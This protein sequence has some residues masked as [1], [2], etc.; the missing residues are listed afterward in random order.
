MRN[1]QAKFGHRAGGRKVALGA[2]CSE[3]GVWSIAT[4]LARHDAAMIYLHQPHVHSKFATSIWYIFCSAITQR[5]D[6]RP[7]IAPTRATASSAVRH[8]TLHLFETELATA[9]PLASTGVPRRI[10][11]GEVVWYGISTCSK[12]YPP[13]AAS[14][15]LGGD[16]SP[17]F[18]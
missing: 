1:E 12:P 4:A 14:A 11:I 18:G 9:A 10:T 17:S 16:Q 2:F 15:S 5:Q 8:Q 3:A 6:N 7:S 13:C